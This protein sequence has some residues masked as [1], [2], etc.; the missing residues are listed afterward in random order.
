MSPS[1][2]ST[3]SSLPESSRNSADLFRRRPQTA[4]RRL[5]RVSRD[6]K[7]ATVF[8]ADGVGFISIPRPPLSTFANAGLPGPVR[9]R[10]LSSRSKPM[11]HGQY[12]M[13]AD[14]TTYC[15]TL[16]RMHTH[17][18]QPLLFISVANLWQH[19][20][21]RLTHHLSNRWRL[22]PA[23]RMLPRHSQPHE[24]HDQDLQPSRQA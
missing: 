22:Y 16:R 8:S 24:R 23:A 21:D 1:M 7:S 18:R 9:V 17:P 19:L 12:W 6:T 14:W 3:P 10:V 20:T 2:S 11:F 4:D 15:D 13:Q 5:K